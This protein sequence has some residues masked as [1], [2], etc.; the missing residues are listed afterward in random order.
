MNQDSPLSDRP[1]DSDRPD[2]NPL[3]DSPSPDT[4]AAQPQFKSTEAESTGFGAAGSLSH[5]PFDTESEE[6]RWLREQS[7]AKSTDGASG[8]NAAST[9]DEE[10]GKMKGGRRSL[11]FDVA[12]VCILALGLAFVLRTFIAQ[13]YE[14]RG[15]SMRPTLQDGQRVMISKLSP[16][17]DSLDYEDIVIFS[18]PSSATRDLIK[19]VIGLPGDE[20]IVESDKVIVNGETRVETY[21][22]RAGNY[23]G[24]IRRDTLEEGEIFVLGDNR[25]NSKDSRDF[26]PIP[27]QS[28]K[29]KVFLRLWPLNAFQ[30]FP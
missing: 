1:E 7:A 22:L 26:G 30:T 17:V 20:V 16:Q 10:S 5:L 4:E 29:G 25:A 21:I 2:G 19:R 18:D 27:I 8:E 28:V 11:L 14:I 3:P 6:T 15:D 12:V 23:R 13:A 9:T 24:T